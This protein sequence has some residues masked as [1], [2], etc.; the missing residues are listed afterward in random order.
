MAAITFDH[1]TT[2]Y[3]LPHARCLAHAAALAY[4]NANDIETTVNGWG[5]DRYAFFRVPHRPPF[6]LE[7]TQAYVAASDRMI[8]AAFRGT[9]PLELR[10]WLSDANV[11]MT[12]Y[13]AGGTIHAGFY[14]ALDVVHA[15]LRD[16]IAKWRTDDQT[17][18]F[19]GHSLG[20]ALA[21]IAA[22][23]TYFE[24]PA[25]LAD[26]VYTF[27]QPRTCDPDLAAAYDKVFRGRMLRFVNNNDVVARLPPAPLYQHVAEERY[28][29]ADGRLRETM[30]LLASV[31]DRFKGRTADL[32]APGAD[33][34]R[35]HFIDAYLARFETSHH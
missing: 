20:G 7:D 22:A 28:F 32:L 1:A 35:D 25:L 2:R 3:S 21:M 17:L 14:Q 8:I 31:A 29:D 19:T 18:W 30:T 27:G 4:K 13:S 5:F 16:T 10:D 24:D 23:R 6:P 33:G 11:L 12:P 26:G 9:Q 34:V 15:E